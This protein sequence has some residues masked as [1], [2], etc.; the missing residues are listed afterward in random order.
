MR[1]I[2][3]AVL[4][5]ALLAPFSFA[6]TPDTPS[7]DE[8]L[9]LMDVLGARKTMKSA[10]D[11]MG[12]LMARSML[13]EMKKKVPNAIPEQEKLMSELVAGMRQDMLS[14]MNQDDML[15]LIVPVYQKH[16]TKQEVKMVTDFY[17]SPAGQAFVQKIPLVLNEAMQ[18]GADYGRTRQE[19]L[20]KLLQTRLAEFDAKI[21]EQKSKPSNVVGGNTKKD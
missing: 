11:G 19:Q 20:Q 17:S 7:H 3:L 4:A 13:D 18:V 21:K 8:V 10:M 12:D 16:L 6:Q 9:K 5:L 15:E 1:R 14:V 2:V